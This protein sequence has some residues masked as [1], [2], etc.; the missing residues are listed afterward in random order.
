MELAISTI[1]LPAPLV[2]YEVSALLRV[3]V[4]TKCRDARIVTDLDE[5]EPWIGPL[6]IADRHRLAAEDSFALGRVSLLLTSCA[7]IGLL[8]AVLVLIIMVLTD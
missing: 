6:T 1:D 3:D 2:S 4:P 5:C 7:G 8:L